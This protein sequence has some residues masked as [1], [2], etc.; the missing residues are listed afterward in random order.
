MDRDDLR[1]LL[2]RFKAGEVSTDDALETLS[3]MPFEDIGEARIDHHRALR[4]GMPEVIF[5]EGKTPQQMADIVTAMAARGTN[6]LA[7]RIDAA[8]AADIDR[9]LTA[10][11]AQGAV[12]PD[13]SYDP[14]GRT[15]AL[16]SKPFVDRGRGLVTVACAG[17]SDLPVAREALVTAE[18]MDNRTELITDIGVAGLHRL[19]SQRERLSRA[20]V[21]IVVAGM[22]GALPGV[23]SGLIGRPVVAVPTSVG[24]GAAFE[25]VAALLT[26]LNSCAPGVTVV[27]IDNGYGAAAAATLINR[28]RDL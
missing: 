22:E 18:M 12:M 19:L 1:A 3:V 26:M 6:I 21:I 16:R 13:W 5:G 24:Y 9:L 7:T 15:L 17:T 23:L 11:R 2:E 25:G 28:K 8:K 27:N 14:S 20:E 4:T 10:R